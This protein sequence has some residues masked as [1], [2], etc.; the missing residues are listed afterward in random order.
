MN[1]GVTNQ[2]L[3]ETLEKG[4]D[5]VADSLLAWKKASLEREKIEAHLLLRYKAEDQKLNMDQIKALVKVNDERYQACLREA[6]AESD[7]QRIYE[8][9][10]SA[11]KIASFYTAY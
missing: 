2:K 8:R 6:V 7:Y 10:L 11:K 5:E 1:P 4:A 9:L 3:I